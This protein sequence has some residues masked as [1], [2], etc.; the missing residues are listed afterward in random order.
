MYVD[1]RHSYRVSRKQVVALEDSRSSV[2]SESAKGKM[3]KLLVPV[4]V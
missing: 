4:L 1:W 2:R 3:G